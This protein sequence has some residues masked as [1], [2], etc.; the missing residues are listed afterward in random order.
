[1]SRT[2]PTAW[3]AA[4]ATRI[5]PRNSFES[6]GRRRKA[7]REPRGRRPRPQHE[8]AMTPAAAVQTP[9]KPKP[10]PSSASATPP[11]KRAAALLATASGAFCLVLVAALVFEHFQHK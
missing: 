5:A 3:P 4:D 9:R 1:M 11:W 10:P 2:R 6:S 8:P 7:R